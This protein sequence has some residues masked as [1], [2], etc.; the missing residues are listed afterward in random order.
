MTEAIRTVWAA[1]ASDRGLVRRRNEDGAWLDGIFVRDDEASTILAR[2]GPHAGALLAVADGVGGA[3]AGDV[4]SR[5]V[6]EQIA[7][8]L[9]ATVSEA[10]SEDVSGWLDDT[11]HA[12]NRRLVTRALNSDELSGMATTLT[13]IYLT[14]TSAWW[15]NA[16]DSRL[17]VLQEG[18]LVQVSRDHTLRELTGDP[19][20]PGNIIANCF[21]AQGEFYLD[22]G[23]LPIMNSASEVAPDGGLCLLCTD[24][25]TDYADHERLEAILRDPEVVRSPEAL[26]EAAG[27]LVAAARDGGGGDNITCLLAVAVSSGESA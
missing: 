24:G 18:G 3:A 11:A 7:G 1:A 9:G 6:L 16:G 10:E 2:P 26:Q 22:V 8:L 25:L 27:R 23:E 20:I 15:F 17:Y 14:S 4:A 21:G 19:R 5:F 12:V 13:G